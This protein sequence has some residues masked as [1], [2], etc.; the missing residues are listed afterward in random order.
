[1]IKTQGI[2]LSDRPPRYILNSETQIQQSGQILETGKF[3]GVL[4]RKQLITI[5]E[6]YG[7][8]SLASDQITYLPKGYLDHKR[9]YKRRRCPGNSMICS[10]ASST[11]ITS[12]TNHHNPSII[13]KFLVSLIKPVYIFLCFFS[14]RSCDIWLEVH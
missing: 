14:V 5:G 4:I 12:T 9:K 7:M 3:S 8:P 2:P 10:C 13:M 6:S 11:L 1:M